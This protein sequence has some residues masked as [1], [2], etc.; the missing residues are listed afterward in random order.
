MDGWLIKQGKVVKS[1]RRR[2]F[3]LQGKTLIYFK[4][5]QMLNKIDMGSMA[6]MI[7]LEGCTV[8]SSDEFIHCF[9]IESP[10]RK[11]KI[12]AETKQDKEEWMRML[13]SAINS[14]Q[15]NTSQRE[16][17]SGIPIVPMREIRQRIAVDSKRL[18]KSRRRQSAH[19]QTVAKRSP[20]TDRTQKSKSLQED[21]P[22]PVSHPLNT[23]GPPQIV[24]FG[25]TGIFGSAVVQN[26]LQK[27][28]RFRLALR[29][30]PEPDQFKG[31][32][33]IVTGVDFNLDE[34][35][36]DAV[37][38]ITTIFLVTGHTP[39]MVNHTEAVVNA[40][41]YF[42]ATHIVKISMVGCQLEPGIQLG[43][44]H[45]QAE[46]IIEN[47]GLSFTFLR[48]NWVF[49]SV[50]R[51]NPDLQ[52][53]RVLR[54]PMQN[55]KVSW[56][57]ANDVA[58][59]AAHAL[60]NPSKHSKQVYALTGSQSLSCTEIAKV[61]S[62]VT[63][64]PVSAVSPSNAEAKEAF[65]QISWMHKDWAAPLVEWCDIVC[66]GFCGDISGDFQQL[67][68]KKQKSWKEYVAEN[69]HLF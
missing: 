46:K 41:K 18:S 44:W 50:L 14:N 58:E 22:T 33:E 54:L 60:T 61:I 51:T 13:H 36:A 47:S 64:K 1:W 12:R 37:H 8:Q 16:D 38:G 5:Q 2:W 6:G 15:S 45:R 29:R 10:G 24:V 11:Y 43:R 23:T 40:A 55:G 69:K 4:K 56:I 26:L 59:V 30:K 49:Q 3:S 9:E 27:K 28:V 32:A 68:Q 62:E 21:H 52:T 34:T 57:D 19:P 66:M 35:L 25:A 39:E 67:I 31:V 65:S 17:S 48:C 7:R 20:L 63:G 53:E 42:E